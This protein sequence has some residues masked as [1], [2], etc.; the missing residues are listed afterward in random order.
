MPTANRLPLRLLSWALACLL[1]LVAWRSLPLIEDWLA[2]KQVAPRT[3]SARGDLAADEKA[4]IELFENARDSVVYITTSR[5]VRDLWT[6]NVFTVPRGTG[7]GFIWDDAGHVI[8]NFH[9]IEGASEAAVKLSD[10]RSYRAVLVGAS[11][12]HG[13]EIDESLNQRLQRALGVT[14]VVILRVV[15]GSAAAAAGLR[16]AT[17][18]ADGSIVAGDVVMAVDGKPVET[19]GRLLARLD[20]HRVGETVR[21]GVL[22]QGRSI[23]VAVVLE[24]GV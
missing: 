8:T 10:G 18:A 16:G 1:L 20:D 12:A 4:I 5:Q 21:L 9:V 19:V 11:P 15:P 7:S 13:I 23:E 24:P 17:L 14:G 6:R 2:P 3:V 22:R